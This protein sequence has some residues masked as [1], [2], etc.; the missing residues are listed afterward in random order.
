MHTYHFIHLSCGGMTYSVFTKL[1]KNLVEPVLY[2]GAGIWGHTKWREVKPIQN[3]DCRLFLGCHKN[4]SNIAIQ[5]DVGF[6]SQTH[7]SWWK[8]I[9]YFYVIEMPMPI[10]TFKMY[11]SSLNLGRSW[12][13]K[14]IETARGIAF[15]DILLSNYSVSRKLSEIRVILHERDCNGWLVELNND[16]ILENGNKLRTYRKYKQ[17]LCTSKYVISV[18]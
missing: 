12:D 14:C 15:Y 7:I 1:Y 2:Y 18:K 5:G 10:L 4:A 9:D 6:M 3:K 13:R 11:T 8:Y 16:R 17:E